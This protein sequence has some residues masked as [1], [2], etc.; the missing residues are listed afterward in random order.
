MFILLFIKVSV[1][2]S[3]P[4]FCVCVKL[5]K[6]LRNEMSYFCELSRFRFCCLSANAKG[7]QSDFQMYQL[8]C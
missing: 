7:S 6:K 5:S 3:S 1:F 4:R 8:L 2:I